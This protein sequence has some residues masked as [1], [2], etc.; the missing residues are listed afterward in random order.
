MIFLDFLGVLVSPP[1][2]NNVGLGGLD[3]S[4]IP[5]PFNFESGFYCTN[6]RQ[7]NSRKLLNILFQHMSPI[8]GPKITRINPII[9]P[10]FVPIFFPMICPIT[11][12]PPPYPQKC[13]LR[14]QS[15]QPQSHDQHISK[16][17]PGLCPGRVRS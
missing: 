12:L 2:I 9:R 5:K 13:I 10:I 16:K 3:M 11:S 7:I 4:K 1:K 14:P 8:N 17:S 15:L 6:L